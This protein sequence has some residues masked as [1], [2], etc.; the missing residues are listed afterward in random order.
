LRK[1]KKAA[2]DGI[3]YTQCN[4]TIEDEN[5]NEVA[6]LPWYGIE[7]SEDDVVTA[8]F[9]NFGFYGEWYLV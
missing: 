3:S 4:V 6:D 7:P 1:Q 8:Q 2:E 5:G 9:G